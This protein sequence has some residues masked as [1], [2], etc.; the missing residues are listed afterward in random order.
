MFDSMKKKT[1]TVT[2]TLRYVKRR[3]GMGRIAPVRIGKTGLAEMKSRY[4]AITDR[5]AAEM[6]E[7]ARNIAGTPEYAR[8]IADTT[9]YER[10]IAGTEEYAEN[11]VGHADNSVGDAQVSAGAAESMKDCIDARLFPRRD[12]F[13][14]YEILSFNGDRMGKVL[15]KDGVIYRGIYR[16]SCDDFREMWKTGLLQVLSR[17]GWIPETEVS[18]YYTDEY[19]IILRHQTV[20]MN[21]SKLWSYNMVREAAIRI[22]HIREIAGRVGFTLHDGHLNNVT[23][24]RGK[25][26]FTDIGSFVKDRGQQTV[27]NREIV[28]SGCYSCVFRQ[29]GNFMLSRNQTYDEANNMIWL[30]PRYYDDLTEEY[31][32]ALRKFRSYHRRHSSGT[33]KRILHRM[34]DN[35]DVRPWY[36]E[37]LFPAAVGI[38]ANAYAQDVERIADTVRE[39]GLSISSAVDV[40][41]TKGRMSE[42]LYEEFGPAATRGGKR[43]EDVTD[44]GSNNSPGRV[45]EDGKRV[46]DETGEEPAETCCGT[47]ETGINAEDD[48]AEVFSVTACET[49]DAAC[50]MAFNYFT[51]KNVPGNVL[52]FHYLYG[53]DPD[54]RKS[55]MADLA[56]CADITHN[57]F[58]VQQYRM[59]SLLNSLRKMAAKYVAV[60]YYPMRPASE[61]FIR[62]LTD[63]GVEDAGEF[64]RVFEG[65]FDI[66]LKK[67][68]SDDEGGDS[69]FL[70][71]G[72]VR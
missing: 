3:R 67:E 11:M 40:G 5:F 58:S 37:A 21:A 29:L 17:H 39:L 34:F 36:I 16:E 55:V 8:N 48:T 60:T 33:A 50:D 72:R 64:L 68:F 4:D 7:Y 53:C 49:D 9:G 23:F 59:D 62:K 13:T 32:L 25:P 61:K 71:V 15:M 47:D 38:G 24:H 54:S 42:R 20:Q 63:A 2:R 56:T 52:A 45:T 70:L 69:C 12:L 1:N 30:T 27:C 35:W 31:R 14:G 19:P 28:F 46:E 41:G 18:G 43:L 57:V 26:V 22:S 44:H 66:L 6:A 51:E 10:N 65:F